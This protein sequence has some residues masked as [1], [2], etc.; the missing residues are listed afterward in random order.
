MKLFRLLNLKIRMEQFICHGFYRMSPSYWLSISK[1][2]L[3]FLI[4]LIWS[5]FSSNNKNISHLCDRMEPASA[6]KL[7]KAFHILDTDGKGSIS[8]DFISKL[9]SEEGEPFTQVCKYILFLFYCIQQ[10]K[11]IFVMVDDCNHFKW[12]YKTI[13]WVSETHF[14]F[15]DWILLW[16]N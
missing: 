3:F 6:E 16:V 7:L 10:K 9:M 13:T 14:V 5:F 8:K 4:W 1:K 12:P 11:H 15:N 2:E